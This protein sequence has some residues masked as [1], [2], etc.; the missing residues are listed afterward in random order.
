[1]GVL[2]LLPT[3]KPRAITNGKLSRR[4][5]QKAGESCRMLAGICKLREIPRR[6]EKTGGGWEMQ[7]V[8]KQ[9]MGKMGGSAGKMSV[10]YKPGRDLGIGFGP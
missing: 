6:N 9:E 1:M 2:N 7:D 8:W 4:E 3:R 5:G 10:V